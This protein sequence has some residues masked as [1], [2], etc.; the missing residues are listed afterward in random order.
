MWAFGLIQR[1]SYVLKGDQN[2]V[3]GTAMRHVDSPSHLLMEL[4][5]V[6]RAMQNH[7]L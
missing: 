2:M 7:I 5:Q 6:G 4:Y 1:G 3:D